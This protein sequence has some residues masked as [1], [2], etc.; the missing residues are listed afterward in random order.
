[1]FNKLKYPALNAKLKGMYASQLTKE[2][3][4]ELIRQNNIKET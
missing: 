2:E 1:M 4:Y 3:L